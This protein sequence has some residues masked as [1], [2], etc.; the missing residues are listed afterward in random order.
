MRYKYLDGYYILLCTRSLIRRPP[1]RG[2]PGLLPAHHG[3]AHS[4]ARGL[5]S[6]VRR[7]NSGRLQLLILTCQKA[8]GKQHKLHTRPSARFKG[9]GGGSAV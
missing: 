2:K 3:A 1:K 5:I 8:L 6:N 7:C 9:F 4:W